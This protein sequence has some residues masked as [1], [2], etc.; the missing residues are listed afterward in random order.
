[1]NAEVQDVLQAY[2]EDS[3]PTMSSV[4]IRDVAN[5]TTGW[6]CDLYAYSLEHGQGANRVTEDLVLR[7]YSGEGAQDKSA[8]EFRIIK[9]LY[10]VGYPVPR[11]DMLERER[12]PF[13][14]PFII[15]E[16]IDGNVLWSKLVSGDE[17]GMAD[18]VSQ[19]CALLVRLHQLDWRLFADV[20]ERVRF[21][22]PYVFVDEWIGIAEGFLGQ[23]PNTGF[24]SIV[25][26]LKE[27]RG[28]LPCRK[29][30]LTHNDFHPSN[31]LLRNAG[32]PVVIDWTGC[33]ISDPRFDLAWTL[34][35]ADSYSGSA[36]SGRV[37]TEYE[38][39]SGVKVDALDPFIVFACTRRLFDAF[40]SL[41]FGAE[42]MGMRPQAVASMK[43]NTAAYE[44][45]YWMLIERTGLTVTAVDE[46]LRSLS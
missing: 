28:A 9:R 16:K 34:I 38:R 29:P 22:D 8:R 46:L 10:E 17:K 31:I 20:Q 35:L 43:L 39:L 33:R 15:M 3:L 41:S 42:R 27:R 40:V 18:F 13:G 44:R 1:M 5:I 21:Q 14:K 23:F 12:S 7:L 37:L 25:D 19:F 24:L 2:Y 11:V 36:L 30:S 32:S 45:V 6:E 4:R 26:W